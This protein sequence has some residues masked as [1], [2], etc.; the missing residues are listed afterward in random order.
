MEEESI[1]D[2]NN[3]TADEFSHASNTKI[4]NANTMFTSQKLYKQ[5]ELTD[6][7][8]DLTINDAEYDES[9]TATASD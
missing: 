6:T 7:L 4:E 1:Q 9:D 2:A 8:R 3:V 5:D